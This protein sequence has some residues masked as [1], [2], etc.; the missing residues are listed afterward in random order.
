MCGSPR[1]LI[2]LATFWP[3]LAHGQAVA[4]PPP[5]AA[6]AVELQQQQVRDTVNGPRC[7][8]ATLEEP[9]TIYVCGQEI[10][11]STGVRSAYIPERNQYVAPDDGGAWFRTNIGPLELSCCSVQGQRGSAAG[12][13]LR[14]RF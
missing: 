9:D 7:R 5:T 4:P 10:D 12:L 13:G 3:G 1:L 11:Q 2:A 14:I 8:P 6:E